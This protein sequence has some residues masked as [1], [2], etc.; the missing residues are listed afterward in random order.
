MPLSGVITFASIYAR[1]TE[2]TPTLNF[3]GI[4]VMRR[5]AP[6]RVGAIS[7]DFNRGD[8]TRG[9]CV[10]HMARRSTTAKLTGVSELDEKASLGLVIWIS[11]KNQS[12]KM[13]LRL[14]TASENRTSRS[15]IPLFE[16]AAA[17]FKSA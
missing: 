17:L 14:K 16:S 2:Y 8:S 1:N 5:V 10:T 12:M 15:W 11:I 7:T 13:R 4:A 3:R 9:I 6:Q